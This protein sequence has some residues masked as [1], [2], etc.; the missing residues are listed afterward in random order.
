VLKFLRPYTPDFVGW[1][2]DFGQST[3]NYDANGH[4]ARVQPIFDS[5]RLDQNNTLQVIPPSQ[6]LDG[7]QTGVVKRCP[8]AA[9]QFPADGSAPFRDSDGK[10]DCDP[11]LAVP[12]S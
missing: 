6:K 9:T 11:S 10:L 5:Y 3:S 4:Y 1:L 8:G 2:R 12:G 7:F